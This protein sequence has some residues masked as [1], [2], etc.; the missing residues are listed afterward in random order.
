VRYYLAVKPSRRSR[1][2]CKYEGRKEGRKEAKGGIDQ[3]IL[4]VKEEEKECY[5]YRRR[6]LLALFEDRKT[7]V[8]RNGLGIVSNHFLNRRRNIKEFIRLLT[9]TGSTCKEVDNGSKQS[10]ACNDRNS[11]NSPDASR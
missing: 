10:D 7:E 3:G 9:R 11:N 1:Y 4:S 2:Y 6:I 8:N 5:Q